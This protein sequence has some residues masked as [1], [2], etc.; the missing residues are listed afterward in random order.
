MELL[1]FKILCLFLIIIIIIQ[2]IIINMLKKVAIDMLN[3]MKNFENMLIMASKIMK[4]K[5]SE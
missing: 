3:D 1:G 5:E 4:K 2:K